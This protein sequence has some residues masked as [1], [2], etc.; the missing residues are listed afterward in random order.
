MFRVSDVYNEEQLARSA[1]FPERCPNTS[2]MPLLQ[3]PMEVTRTSVSSIGSRQI[4]S[5]A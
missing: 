3:I 4:Y 1:G 5:V 2:T